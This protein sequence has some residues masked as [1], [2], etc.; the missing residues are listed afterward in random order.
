MQTGNNEEDKK[1]INIKRTKDK[2]RAV[3]WKSLYASNDINVINDILETNILEVLDIENWM[4]EN[5]KNKMKDRDRKK[6]T[7]MI[8]G[9]RG[10]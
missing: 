4:S 1:N 9:D 5:F 7:T 10:D 6:E 2:M 3:D 8:S